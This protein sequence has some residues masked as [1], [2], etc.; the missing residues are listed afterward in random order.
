MATQDDIQYRRML[1]QLL[2][3]PPILINLTPDIIEEASLKTLKQWFQEL[4]KV[5]QI[6]LKDDNL[7]ERVTALFQ[8]NESLTKMPTRMNE[9]RKVLL[10]YLRP[11]HEPPKFIVSTGRRGGNVSD[12]GGLIMAATNWKERGAL[13]FYDSMETQ[14]CGS[15][16]TSRTPVELVTLQPTVDSITT[17]PEPMAT[18]PSLE[19]QTTDPSPEVQQ[20]HTGPSF[21]LSRVY[22]AGSSSQISDTPQ[23]AI[24]SVLHAQ[25]KDAADLTNVIIVPKFSN[26][27]AIVDFINHPDDMLGKDDAL[28]KKK[29]WEH[30]A[31]VRR[32]VSTKLNTAK[33]FRFYYK[34]WGEAKFKR[35]LSVDGHYLTVTKAMEILSAAT[36]AK[37]EAVYEEAKQQYINDRAPKEYKQTKW[38]KRIGKNITTLPVAK[39][40]LYDT[41]YR[42]PKERELGIR[43]QLEDREAENSGEESSG[44]EE[45]SDEEDDQHVSGEKE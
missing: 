5:I 11:V 9:L 28:L 42:F 38:F 17:Q 6:A 14:P 18:G 21:R 43:P 22:P 32:K 36:D 37:R 23:N 40:T 8:H 20:T 19:V 10:Q 27:Q 45:S 31:G 44:D 7:K 1:Q 26:V 34:L 25:I 35:E 30:K 13:V 15:T 16:L 2:E 39:Q 3:L 33:I 41:L 24:D 12:L 29:P 4:K